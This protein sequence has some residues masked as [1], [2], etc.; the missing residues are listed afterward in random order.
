M[1][2][3]QCVNAAEVPMRI[4]GRL[5]LGN[6]SLR[7]TVVESAGDAIGLSKELESCIR[8]LCRDLEVPTPIWLEKNT[9]EFARFHQT[10]FFEGQFTDRVPFDR[11]QIRWL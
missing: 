9:R 6:R 1:N 3:E 5:F 7:E 11:L 4:E 10:I 8:T 2:D